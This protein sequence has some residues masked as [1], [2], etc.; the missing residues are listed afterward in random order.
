MKIVVVGG[1]GLIGSKLVSKLRQLG[2]IVIAASPTS[3][4]DTITGE[5]LQEALRGADVVV[6]ASNSPS[7]KD[8]SVM[9]FFQRSTMNLLT[10]GIYAGVKHHIALSVVGTDRMPE[11]GYF[12]AKLAQEDMINTSGIPYSILR[13]TQFFEFAA[14]IAQA[15]TIGE[16]VYIS[17][18]AIQPIASEEA[19]L[20]LA[21]L[22]QGPPVMG[23]V[24]VAGPVRMPMFE[25]IHYYLNAIEDS[26]QVVEDGEAL[27]FGAKL[28]DGSL[29]PGDNPRLGKIKYEDWFH[30]QL[31]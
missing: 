31:V 11:S 15:G 24:E 4:V 3:G 23:I 2:H 27:Y 8:R 21:D 5:G 12:R 22:V 30:A 1:T 14:R 25:L 9:E 7:F 19:V 29:V 20:A 18:A 6:D 16:E 17:P 10:A 13:S 26:R 28:D